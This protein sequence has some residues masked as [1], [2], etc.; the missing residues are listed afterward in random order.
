MILVY[1]VGDQRKDRYTDCNIQSDVHEIKSISMSIF[2]LNR[3]VVSW[4]WSKESTTTNFTTK[5]KYIV[6]CDVAKEVEWRKKFLTELHVVLG[7]D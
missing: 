1:E 4:K 3:G 6:A 5:A 7:I 2:I